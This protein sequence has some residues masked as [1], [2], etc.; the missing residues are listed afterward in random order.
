MDC[1]CFNLLCLN[2]A[3]VLFLCRSHTCGVLVADGTSTQSFV[4][5]Q[6]QPLLNPE[7]PFQSLGIIQHQ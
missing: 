2:G 6:L 3:H 5:S 1:Y 7:T 4:V